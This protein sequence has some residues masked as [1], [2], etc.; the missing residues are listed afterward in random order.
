VAILKEAIIGLQSELSEL[1][2]VANQNNNGNTGI[3]FYIV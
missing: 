1:K 2:K 3:I